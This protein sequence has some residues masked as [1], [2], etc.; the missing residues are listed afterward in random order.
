MTTTP[1]QQKISP[2]FAN[3]LKRLNANETV[4]AIL[5]LSLV[6]TEGRL[7]RGRPTVEERRQKL[8]MLRQGSETMLAEIDETLVRFAGRRLSPNV[9]ALGSVLVETTP[10]GIQALVANKH[11]KAILEDQPVAL[12]H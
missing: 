3:R 9:D 8:R 12:I 10:D 6:D 2:E 7:S 4:R 5:M 1:G 11:T